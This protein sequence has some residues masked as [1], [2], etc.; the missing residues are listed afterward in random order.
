MLGLAML[1]CLPSCAPT[2][3]SL[4]VADRKLIFA[5]P[6]LLAMT[7]AEQRMV[8]NHNETLERLCPHG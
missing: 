5:D 7:S 6:A 2:G 8:L 4:C 3:D 1:T